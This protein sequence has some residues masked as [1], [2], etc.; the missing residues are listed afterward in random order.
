[1]PAE[2]LSDQERERYQSI[3]SNLSQEDLSRYCFLS[4]TDRQLISGMRRD[5][6][7]L[8]FALQLAVLRLMNHLP[9][10]WYRKVPDNLVSYV[11]RQL[12]I[13]DPAILINYGNREKTVS[14]HLYTIL[15]YLKRRR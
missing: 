15:L 6:N 12:D 5:H 9:Q 8:G 14:E 4:N 10:E 1:M 11:A 13:N 7:R 2:F 3:P